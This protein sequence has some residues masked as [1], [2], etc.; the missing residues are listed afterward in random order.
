MSVTKYSQFGKIDE[1]IPFFRQTSK[2]RWEIWI[3]VR[4][5]CRCCLHL[6]SCRQSM[7]PSKDQVYNGRLLLNQ[8]TPPRFVSILAFFS[9]LLFHVISSFPLSLLLQLHVQWICNLN[10]S[11]VLRCLGW[12]WHWDEKL[13]SV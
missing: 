10:I 1:R 9:L 3:S 7:V 2:R 4:W 6:L 12:H 8:T 13:G 11:K 5:C